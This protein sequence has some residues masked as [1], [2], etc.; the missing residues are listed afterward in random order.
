MRY[1]RLSTDEKRVICHKE[2]EEPGTGT[3]CDT[4]LQGVY[5]CRQCDAPLFLS[6]DKFP[7]SCGW[8]A[9]DD[10]IQGAIA[11]QPDGERT[12]VLCQR[13]SAHLGHLFRGERLTPKDIRFCV[14]SCSLTFVPAKT[15]E[16]YERIYLAGGCFWGVEHFM[17]ECEGVV[18]TRVGYIGGRSVNPSYEEVCSGTTNHAEG[19]EV[20]F[21]PDALESVLKYFFE[22]HDPFQYMQQ[23]VDKGSQY[24]SAI[25]Y[26]TFEQRSVAHSLTAFLERKGEKV[27]TE[28]VPASLFYPAEERHQ[29]YHDKM[30]GASSCHMRKSRFKA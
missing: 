22:I 17:Q 11:S 13:C 7:S 15:E 6:S 9:F 14:N 30:G 24:R 16:G 4:F 1:H 28:I 26:L 2:T 21:D 23:G 20:I 8:P 29:H 27:A 18:R 19:V 25:F 10:K 12:E 3:Y 5:L